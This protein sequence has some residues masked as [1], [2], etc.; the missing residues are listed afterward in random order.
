MLSGVLQEAMKCVINVLM[1]E[2]VVLEV[3]NGDF[4]DRA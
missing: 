2:V 4:V 3:W 1:Q